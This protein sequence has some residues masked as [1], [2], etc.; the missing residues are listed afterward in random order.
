MKN[1]YTLK[2]TTMKTII[3]IFIFVF[4]LAACTHKKPAEADLNAKLEAFKDSMKLAADTAGLADYQQWKAQNEIQQQDQINEQYYMA[5][6]VAS[7]RKTSTKRYYSSSGTRRSGSYASGSSNTA[8][9]KKGWSKA[10]KG[11]AI[12]G[13]SGAVIGAVVHKKNRLAGGVVGGIV[14]GAVG[15]GIGRHMDKRDGRY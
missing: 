13:G 14:G 5:A 6:P 10:A 4:I 3:S 8:R 1:I 9:A 11:A 12:G 15:Y 7:A 2:T